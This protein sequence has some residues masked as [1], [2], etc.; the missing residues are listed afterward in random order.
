MAFVGTMLLGMIGHKVFISESRTLTSSEQVHDSYHLFGC[1]HRRY[2]GVVRRWGIHSCCARACLW[3]WIV[4]KAR[5]CSVVACCWHNLRVRIGPVCAERTCGLAC[6]VIFAATAMVGAYAG[7]LAADW[8]EGRTLLLLFAA[9]MVL[10][11]LAM[12][13]RRPARD[14]VKRDRLPWALVAL[15]GIGVGGRRDLLVLV[16]GFLLCPH[17][18]F[19]G[20]CPSSEPWAHS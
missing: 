5:H 13:K 11:A 14:V 20:E 3:R 19:L 8:F 9:M 6:G 10:T 17:W 16:V 4:A 2:V 7:G 1:H 12:L 15:E 18:C